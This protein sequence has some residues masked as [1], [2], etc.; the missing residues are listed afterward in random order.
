MDQVEVHIVQPHVAQGPLA[1]HLN[2]LL[3]VVGVPQLG[4]DKELLAG[5]DPGFDCAPVSRLSSSF[6]WSNGKHGKV[7]PLN[8]VLY[9]I[10]SPTSFSLP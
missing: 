7:C 2:M 1:R 6:V 3:G 10:P 5:A 4:S 8:H 9:L